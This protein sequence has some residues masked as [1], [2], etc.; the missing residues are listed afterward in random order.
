MTH[1]YDKRAQ[2]ILFDAYWRPA[3]GWNLSRPSASDLAYAKEAGYMFDP[4]RWSHEEV[5]TGVISAVRAVERQD[6]A[7]AFLSSLATRRLE[8]RSALGSYAQFRTY[9]SHEWQ[10]RAGTFAQTCVLCRWAL[11]P[12]SDEDLNV[13]NFERHKWGGVRHDDP[14]YALF[15]LREFQKLEKAEHWEEGSELLK[16]ILATAQSLEPSAK[17][18]DLERALSDTFKSN[19]GEREIVLTILAYCGVLNPPDDRIVPYVH[20]NDWREPIFRWRG[21]DGV[22]EDAA[23]FWFPEAC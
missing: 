17:P 8:Y 15:D 9:A 22:D 10:P 7:R 21:E 11:M 1:T 3:K 19:K 6:V 13:L 2:Q 14:L 12:D 20:K 5:T 16:K 23:R 18:R 4:V